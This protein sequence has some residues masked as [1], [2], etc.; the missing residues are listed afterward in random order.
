MILKVCSEKLVVTLHRLC[1]CLEVAESVK[2]KMHSVHV[3][4]RL[5]GFALTSSFQH[6]LLVKISMYHFF[7][8]RSAVSQTYHLSAI[9]CVFKT[10][11]KQTQQRDRESMRACVFSRG[12]GSWVFASKALIVVYNTYIGGVYLTSNSDRL[13]SFHEPLYHIDVTLV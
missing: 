9:L 8:L 2:E 5:Q 6:F 4:F 3:Q 7:F 10:E 1:R 11:E 13:T 12:E